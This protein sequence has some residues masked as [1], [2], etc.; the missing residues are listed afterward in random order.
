MLFVR[1]YVMDKQTNKKKKERRKNFN[2]YLHTHISSFRHIGLTVPSDG[3][4]RF[5]FCCCC[6]IFFFVGFSV[7]KFCE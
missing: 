5:G 2:I 4:E 6:D 1:V 7:G 3:G